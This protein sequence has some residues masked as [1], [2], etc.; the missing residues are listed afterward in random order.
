V[1]DGGP[2]GRVETQAVRGDKPTTQVGRRFV[3]RRTRVPGAQPPKVIS[4]DAT[5]ADWGGQGGRDRLLS[6][7]SCGQRGVRQEVWDRAGLGRKKTNPP[8]CGP[9]PGTSPSSDGTEGDI[10]PEV[11]R[12]WQLAVSS[13]GSEAAPEGCSPGDAF[14]SGGGRHLIVVPLRSSDGRGPVCRFCAGL[15]GAGFWERHN[16]LLKGIVDRAA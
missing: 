6:V 2:G 4:G 14:G 8:T 15:S 1:G 13:P 3:A 11:F 7:E 5:S 12:W 10:S 9:R 16:R